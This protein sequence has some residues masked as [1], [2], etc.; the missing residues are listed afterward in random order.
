ALAAFYAALLGWPPPQLLYDDTWA[1]LVDP[2]GGMGI[3]FQPAPDY[4]PPTWPDPTRPQ[5]Y[6]FDFRVDDMAAAQAHAIAVG[7]RPLD[8][9]EDRPEFQVY[10]DPA[11]HPFCLCAC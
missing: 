3:E 1:S 9:S 6:H 10:A 11:G 4:Q 2:D 5:M 8:V 7:A